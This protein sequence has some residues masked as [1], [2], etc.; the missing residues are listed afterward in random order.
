[1][2]PVVVLVWLLLMTGCSKFLEE[3][4]HDEVRPSSVEDLIALMAGEAYPYNS[5]FL[6][7]LPLLTDDVQCNGGQNQTE[8]L[9]VT[10]KGKS[11]FS[12]SKDMFEELVLP[13]GLAAT[14]NVNVWATLYKKIAGCNT[15]IE[16]TGKV[17]G[18]EAT[19]NYLKGEALCM[20]SYYYLMLVNFFGKPYN[21]EGLD[22]EL[23]PGV[24]LKLTMSVNDGLF[25]R[26]SVAE[27]YRQIEADL[28]AGAAL[29]ADNQQPVNLYKFTPAAANAL[30]SRV[31]LYQEKWEDAI[32]YADKVITAKPELANLNNFR[33]GVVAGYYRYNTG[34][35]TT[36]RANDNRIYS[37]NSSR[38]VLW[39]YRPL[40]TGTGRLA[41][42]ELLR[43]FI[44][45][46]YSTTLNPPYAVSNELLSLYDM[47][48]QADTSVY[49]GDLRS[50]IYLN[51]QTFLNFATFTIDYKF[52][53]GSDG[54]GGAGI[55]TAEVYLNR[56]EAN[57]HRYLA[58]GDAALRQAALSDI[59]TLRATRYDSRKA[60]NPITIADGNEL[61]AF[62][63]NERRRELAFDGEHRWFDLRRYG[64]PPLTHT[65]SEAPASGQTFTLAKADNRYTLPIPQVVLSRNA[66]LSQNP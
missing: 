42:D 37:L 14:G 32:V 64:M 4:S 41:G 33:G 6:P 49:L 26:N 24:P 25:A 57:V 54:L 18:S 9:A 53:G 8:F 61:L 13:T 15:V 34:F 36:E 48:P 47:A 59:N 27:V 7:V 44:S 3:Q 58:T 17:Q 16:Y 35:A 1:M 46:G 55:R 11:A 5:T 12:W 31:Y 65:Y 52:L 28:K 23:S 43:T 50:R 40:G 56:A 22:P 39:L 21:T 29:M 66:Q 20:R 51:T 45:P 62:Y 2:L 60:Y 30:L 38:E 19:K 63:K 10:V